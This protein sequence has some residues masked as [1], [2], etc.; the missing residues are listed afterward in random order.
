MY[1]QRHLLSA[2]L[3]FIVHS[4]ATN[5]V[6][7]KMR[8]YKSGQLAALDLSSRWPTCVAYNTYTSLIELSHENKHIETNVVE[9]V[10]IK[11]A[12]IHDESQHVPIL[13]LRLWIRSDWLESKSCY[14]SGVNK[15]ERLNPESDV[16]IYIAAAR[17]IRLKELLHNYLSFA[18]SPGIHTAIDI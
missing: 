11:W 8:R 14:L 9:S 6:D 15:S 13:I 18:L 4:N 12:A 10:R 7:N 5:W 3:H 1:I 17:P 16:W 2:S